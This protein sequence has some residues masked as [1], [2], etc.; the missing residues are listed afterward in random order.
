MEMREG[1]LR[2]G[3]GVGFEKE[4]KKEREIEV[5]RGSNKSRT[6]CDCRVKGGL[7]LPLKR[8]RKQRM[9]SELNTVALQHYSSGV[10]GTVGKHFVGIFRKLA[11][12][13]PFTLLVEDEKLYSLR[14]LRGPDP[15][16]ASQSD[17]NDRGR[18]RRRLCERKQ[19]RGKR[20]KG[21][22]QE[23]SVLSTLMSLDSKTRLVTSDCN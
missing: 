15:E 4:R 6:S 5:E 18:R 17:A 8:S 7:A 22:P 2:E 13:Q 10:G 11:N 1:V 21:H 12:S 19:K 16:N 23:T 3:K 9:R 20:A 14:L